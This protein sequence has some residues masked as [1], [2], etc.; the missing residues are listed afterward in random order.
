MARDT[1]RHVAGP[2][3]PGGAFLVLVAVVIAGSVTVRLV[4]LDRQ[5][6]WGDELF[7][8]GESGGSPHTLAAQAGPE[9]HPPLYAAVLWGWIRLGGPHEAWTR[10]LSCGFAI[11]AVVVAWRGLRDVRLTPQVRWALATAVAAGGTSIVYSL[12][13]RSYALLLLGSV[14]LTAATLRVAL[15][16]LDGERT[17]RSV[18]AG[19]LGWSLLAATTHL[20]GAVLTA[21]TV[22]V[23]TVLELRRRQGRAALGWVGRGALG[24]APQAAWVLAGLRRPGFPARTSWISAPGPQDVRDLVTTTFASGGLTPHKDGF[25]WTSPIGVCVAV[26]VCAAAAVTRIVRRRSA[27]AAA[28]VARAGTA[29]LPAALVLL[30]LVVVVTATTFAVSSSSAPLDV[31]SLHVWTLRNLLVVAPAATWGVICLAAAAAGSPTGRRS[32]ATAAVALLGVALVPITAGAALPYKP[33]FRA[34]EAYL[35]AVQRERPGLTVLAFSASP[36]AAWHAAGDLPLDDPAWQSLDART[37]VRPVA[38]AGSVRRGPGTQ[39]V[40]LFRGVDDA[41]PDAATAQLVTRLGPAGCRRIPVHGLGVV[42]CD[43]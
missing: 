12:E 28:H 39:V 19:W 2:G 30:A 6:Y 26:G 42:R 10:L 20:F 7:S 1:S 32:V 43:P 35:L 40:V 23:L 5:S 13:T 31:P 27:R 34:L 4:L 14:G 38:A 17:A 21:G 33:D 3:S 18:R 37:Q 9:I 8:V 24:C 15:A 41:R 11:A 16:L 25:A 22:A 36:P 29:E